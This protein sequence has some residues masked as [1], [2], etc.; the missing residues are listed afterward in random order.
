MADR[1]TRL[2]SG[3]VAQWRG[4]GSFDFLRGMKGMVLVIGLGGDAAP[5]GC[6]DPERPSDVLTTGRPQAVSV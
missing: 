1:W 5:I 6:V 4:G 3:S 2:Y